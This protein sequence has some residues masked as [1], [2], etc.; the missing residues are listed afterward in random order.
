MTA[1]IVKVINIFIRS[2]KAI[3][4]FCFSWCLP[5]FFFL[6]ILRALMKLGV[7]R[8]GPLEIKATICILQIGN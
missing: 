5:I 4:E 3:S 8:V 1:K 7:K 2:Q 6:G